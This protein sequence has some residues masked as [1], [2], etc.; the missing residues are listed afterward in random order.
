[1]EDTAR[2]FLPAN[3]AR[4]IADGTLNPSR[5]ACV[6]PFTATGLGIF[7]V[8]G[9]E[10]GGRMVIT[11]GHNT[12][13]FTQSPSVAKAVLATLDGLLHPMQELYNPERGFVSPDAA[14]IPL[15]AAARTMPTTGGAI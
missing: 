12:G 5:K 14:A 7:E 13:G 2:R 15:R 10:D 11:T 8:L 1:L 4:A 6:R 9:T 3:L